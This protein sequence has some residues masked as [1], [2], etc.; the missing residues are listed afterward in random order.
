MKS[1]E[2]KAKDKL[3]NKKLKEI[4]KSHKPQKWEA[5]NRYNWKKE[6]GPFIKYDADWGPEYFL[7]LIIYKLEKIYLSLDTYSLE[8]RETLNVTLAKLKET[9]DLGKYIQNHDYYEKSLK[10]GDDHCAH[11]ILIYKKETDELLGK[12]VQNKSDFDDKDYLELLLGTKAIEK[13]A[14]ENHYNN[15][16][17]Y[18]AYTGEWDSKESYRTWKRLLNKIQ[19]E[20][21]KDLDKFFMMISRNYGKW[22]W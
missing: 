10:W 1:K 6:W 19:K 4:Q 17:I 12:I 14:S 3:F 13:W 18:A 15:S 11:V 20:R 8:V 5:R 7:D 21:Q 16:D 2:W 9:I 22:W